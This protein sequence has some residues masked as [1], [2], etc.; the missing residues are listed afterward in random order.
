MII[1]LNGNYGVGKTTV[2][3][4]I[5]KKLGNNKCGYIYN[6]EELFYFINQNSPFI[7]MKRKTEMQEEE[8]WRSLNYMYIKWL[9]NNFD[10]ILIIPMSIFSQ[11][12]YENTIEKLKNDGIEI[13]HIILHANEETLLDRIT[14][15][16]NEEKQYGQQVNSFPKNHFKE[17]LEYFN[18][19]KGDLN[20]YTDNKI[21]NEI[22]NNI[23]MYIKKLGSN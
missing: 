22:A 13:Y 18:N 11:K 4:A 15:R 14:K 19:L 21:I 20:I 12:Q 7:S 16:E 23:Y 17:H 5:L 9:E 2:A 10:G 8:I 6:P 1:W 3:N